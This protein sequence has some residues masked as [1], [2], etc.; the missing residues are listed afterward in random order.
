MEIY[1]ESINESFDNSEL[2]FESK[3]EL[4]RIKNNFS[5]LLSLSKQP[6]CDIDAGE[7][8]KLHPWLLDIVKKAKDMD[9]I[10]YLRDDAN[11]GKSQLKKL[12]KN[13]EDVQNGTPSKY[14]NVK[15]IQKKIDKGLTVKKIN[16][17]IKWMDTIYKKALNDR[18][19]E[20]RKAS[21]S[22]SGRMFDAI[23]FI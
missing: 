2:V 17:H 12:A 8:D 23:E 20:I 13:V 10:N 7:Y 4:Y 15:Y 21:L 19:K 1:I 14:V 22:E 16:D 9:R 11:K 6:K 18:A 5:T 3:N